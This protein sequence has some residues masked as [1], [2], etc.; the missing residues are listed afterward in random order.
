[1]KPIVAEHKPDTDFSKPDIDMPQHE[2]KESDT[3]D[4]VA[5]TVNHDKQVRLFALKSDIPHV[6]GSEDMR[7]KKG[8]LNTIKDTICGVYAIRN[9]GV[10]VI[11]KWYTEGGDILYTISAGM[12]RDAELKEYINY[13]FVTLEG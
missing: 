13:D 10:N 2:C 8:G 7:G 9:S 6:D 11:P 12:L 3:E 5:E 1:M 4:F